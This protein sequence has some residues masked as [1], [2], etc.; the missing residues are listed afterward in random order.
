MDILHDGPDN[1]QT[2]GFRR[3]GVNLI[4]ALSNIAE[5]AFD[6]IGRLDMTVPSRWKGIKRQEM[7]F[8]L[9]QAPYGFAI[10][11]SIFGL[12]RIEVGQRIFLL[13]LFPKSCELGLDAPPVLVAGWH[14]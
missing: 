3:K 13:L 6:G 1:G 4:G 7:L 5:K 2:T 10:A 9:S 11:L 12:K 8:I 14:S